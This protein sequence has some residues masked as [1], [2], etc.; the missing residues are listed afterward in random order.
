MPL[1]SAIPLFR[2]KDAFL[3]SVGEGRVTYITLINVG[4]WVLPETHLPRNVDH[5]VVSLDGETLRVVD[6]EG[7]ERTMSVRGN[8][9]FSN[10]LL[11]VLDHNTEYNY[12]VDPHGV[13]F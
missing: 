10:H 7:N 13:N 5:R 1:V 3:D 8:W 9:R 2:N 12:M 6:K 4:G 11:Q